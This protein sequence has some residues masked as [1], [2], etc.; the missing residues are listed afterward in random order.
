M[1]IFTGQTTAAEEDGIDIEHQF[2][3]GRDWLP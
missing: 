1:D 2:L 3:H